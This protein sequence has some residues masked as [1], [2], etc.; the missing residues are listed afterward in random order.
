M[1]VTHKIG[2]TERG[3]AGFDMGW[4]NPLIQNKVDGA[5]LISKNITTQF[6]TNVACYHKAGY[7][8]IVHCTC[9]GFGGTELEPNVPDFRDQ[10]NNLSDLIACGFT[11]ANCVLRIDPIFPTKKGIETVN[12]VINYAFS[13]G[14]LPGM[15]V[16][17]SII[18]EYKHVKER[19]KKLG[20]DPLYPGF[21]PSQEQIDFVA[22]CL[23]RWKLKFECCAETGITGYNIS[24]F[25]CISF[26]D[27]IT[28]GL[29]VDDYKTA[30]NPQQRKGCSC[31]SC[32]TELLTNRHPCRNGC[33]YCYWRD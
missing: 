8:M 12:N 30:Y 31:L 10:L 33:V 22:E 2:I 4:V 15:R 9:T 6:V 25:G 1:N 13:I 19:Y 3:D 5:I 28:M 29:N 7:K 27:I 32:K 18:D 17:F 21:S 23:G 20:W 14:L 26:C 11:N 24:H 16:R